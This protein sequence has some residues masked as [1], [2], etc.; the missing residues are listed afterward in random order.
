MAPT[1]TGVH[2]FRKNESSAVDNYFIYRYLGTTGETFSDALRKIKKQHKLSERCSKHGIMFDIEVCVF[3][4][5]TKRMVVID[6]EEGWLKL[7]IVKNK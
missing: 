5:A 3:E 6:S 2:I 4:K 1:V 7:V